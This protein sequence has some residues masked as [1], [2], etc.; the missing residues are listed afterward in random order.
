MP[1]ALCSLIMLSHRWMFL[2]VVVGPVGTVF[3]PASSQTEWSQI[4]FVCMTIYMLFLP[5][6]GTIVSKDQENA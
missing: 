4:I 2:F 5:A 1:S 3:A 6:L